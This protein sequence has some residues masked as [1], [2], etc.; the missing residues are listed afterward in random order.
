VARNFT[1]VS[2]AG[3]RPELS[4]TGLVYVLAV[5]ADDAAK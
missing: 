2:G 3:E 1:Q 4:N 5:W